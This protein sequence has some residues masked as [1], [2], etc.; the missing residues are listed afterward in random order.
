MATKGRV[1][2]QAE[3]SSDLWIE[4]LVQNQRLIDSFKMYMQDHIHKFEGLALD[5]LR[6]GD[7]A[8]AMRLTGGVDM[9]KLMRIRV[10]NED[11]EITTKAKLRGER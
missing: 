8:K 1:R 6:S 10:T 11:R 5:A 2:V 9:A 7:H 4:S 3:V